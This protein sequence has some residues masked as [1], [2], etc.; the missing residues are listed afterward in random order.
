MK[1]KSF[2]VLIL[3]AVV[4]ISLGVWAYYAVK[5][6]FVIE[7][8]LIFGFLLLVVGFAI[9]IGARH[10]ASEKRGEPAAD[11]MSKRIMQKTAASSYYISLYLWVALIFVNSS[12]ELDTETVIGG[13]IIGMSLIFALSWLYYKLRG[14]KNA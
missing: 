12:R 9:F 7:D 4:L 13:G 14:L 5:K 10:L 3:A 8:L 2:F 1:A 6:Q 11:E